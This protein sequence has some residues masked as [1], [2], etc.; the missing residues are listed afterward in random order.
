MTRS[1][2]VCVV[3]SGV[4]SCAIEAEPER[5]VK[6][7]QDIMQN[8][9]TMLQGVQLLGTQLQGKTFKGFQFSGATLNG[10]A[11]SDLHLDKGELVATQGGSELRGAALVNAHVI[12]Q[13]QTAAGAVSTVDY[14]IT[15]IEAEAAGYDPTAT[16]H[17]YLY[18]IAQNVDATGTYQ[19]ACGTDVDGRSAAIPMAAIWNAHGDRVESTTLFTFGCTTGVVAKC[20]RWGYRPWITG[21]GDLAAMH[22]T[23]TRVARAD[24]C[25]N[26]TPHTRDGTLINVWDNLPAPG[27]IQ[28]RATAPVTMLFEAGWNTSGAVCLS[29]ARWLLNGPI[30]ALGCPGRLIAPGLS[31]LGGTVCD[32][33]A[34]VLGQSSG[35]VMFDES[36][37]N[38]NLDLF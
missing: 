23:C 14:A 20:Y 29:H 8:Q 17:T 10:V 38:L 31:L 21:A 35:S 1:I 26:G 11:L 36:N 3:A 34:D 30:I 25:G 28:T 27:P 18:S 7:E 32:T 5:L 24:Y 37:L 22:W 6:V 4:A 15:A 16:G 2:I 33:V 19:A 12:G 13:V 9:G